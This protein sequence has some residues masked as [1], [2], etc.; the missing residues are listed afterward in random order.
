MGIFWAHTPW[1][2]VYSVKLLVSIPLKNL[3]VSCKSDSVFG[4]VSI[5]LVH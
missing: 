3:L 5:L 2:R 1:Y 4:L